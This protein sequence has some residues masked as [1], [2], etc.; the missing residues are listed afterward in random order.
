MKRTVLRVV[1]IALAAAV[2]LLGATAMK[3]Q[4]GDKGKKASKPLVIARR[5]AF[6]PAGRCSQA[7]MEICSTTIT[8]TPT[9]RSR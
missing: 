7:P 1:A 9:T 6:T 3:A 5:G 2:L 8:S 4:E